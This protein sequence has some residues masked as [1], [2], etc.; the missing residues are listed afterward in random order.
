MLF[1]STG[2]GKTELKGK[3]ASIRRQGDY[4]IMHVDVVEP[5]R[6]KIRAAFSFRDLV[7]IVIALIKISILS[8]LL[9]PAQWF[10]KNASHPGQF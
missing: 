2:L 10:K 6:W 5:V 4:V 3:L 8:L 1:R 9:S 7:T